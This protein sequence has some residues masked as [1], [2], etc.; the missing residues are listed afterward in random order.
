[1]PFKSISKLYKSQVMRRPKLFFMV[2]LS[3]SQNI[4]PSLVKVVQHS[5]ENEQS[6]W[7]QLG[8][9]KMSDVHSVVTLMKGKMVQPRISLTDETIAPLIFTSLVAVLIFGLYN[10]FTAEKLLCHVF[11]Y[12]LILSS[13]R[14]FA[15]CIIIQYNF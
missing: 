5:H 3:H 6:E 7:N 15:K 4:N 8:K 1:M 13:V 10:L 12:H 9:E 14:K 11:L 2:L